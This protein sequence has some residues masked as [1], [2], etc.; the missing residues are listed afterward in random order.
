MNRPVLGAIALALALTFAGC[1]EAPQASTESGLT[2]L[3]ADTATVRAA[4][5]A[6]DEAG[7]TDALARL[8][9]DVIQL[10][11]S[12]A[13]TVERAD[14]V[15]AAADGVEAELAGLFA[16]VTTTSFPLATTTAERPAV[17]GAPGTLPTTAVPPGQGTEPNKD[18]PDKDK[19]DRP[20]KDKPGNGN[21]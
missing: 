1:G 16:L 17:P 18:K 13:I 21:G 2:V 19:P 12:N 3:Q 15:L 9:A 10:R 11:D 4:V 7:T 5:N 6:R 14:R 8:R 20:D